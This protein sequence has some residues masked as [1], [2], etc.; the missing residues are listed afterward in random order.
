MVSVA[1]T[2]CQCDCFHM[3]HADIKFESLFEINFGLIIAP[4]N[5]YLPL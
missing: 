5:K 4:A 1:V 2:E 3:K